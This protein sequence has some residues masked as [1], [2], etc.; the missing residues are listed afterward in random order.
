MAY[1]LPRI[2]D[3]LCALSGSS[4]FST[5]DLL[6]GYNQIE[7]CKADVPKTAFI[8]QWGLYEFVRMPFGLKGAPATCQRVVDKIIAGKKYVSVVVYLDDVVVYNKSFDDQLIDL[9]DVLQRFKAADLRFRPDKCRFLANSIQY[10]GHI[11]TDEGIAADPLKLRAVEHFPVPTDVNS[12]RSFLGLT[13]YF[14]K[15]VRGYANLAAPLHEMTKKNELFVMTSERLS[16]FEE[17]KSKLVSAPLLAHFDC[18][19]DIEIHTDASDKGLGAILIQRDEDGNERPVVFLSRSL[20]ANEKS[21][22]TVEKE[23][24]AVVWALDKL[25]CYIYGK[26]FKIITDNSSL[27]WL[28]RVKEGSARLLRWAMRL[29]EFEFEVIHKAGNRNQGPDALSRCPLPVE[30]TEEHDLSNDMLSLVNAVE[31]KRVKLVDQLK[32]SKLQKIIDALQGKG[33]KKSRARMH[34]RYAI[35]DDALYR[36]MSDK[37]ATRKCLC[38]PNYLQNSI[39]TEFHCG[40]SG[41]HMGFD[42]TYQRI[43][44][45]YFWNNM[46]RDINN[47]VKSCDTCQRYQRRYGPKVGHLHPITAN[48]PFEVVGIDLIGPLPN[49]KGGHRF[50]IVAIDYLT[51]YVESKALRSIEA[52]QIQNFIELT[53]ILRHGCPRKIIS[54]RGSQFV[55]KETE[56]LLTARGIELVHTTA[57]KPN[58]NGEVERVN[59]TLKQMLY[60]CCQ[61][62][63]GLWAE[64]L[65]YVVFTYNNS[66]QEATGFD[67]F[68]LVYGRQALLPT[69]VRLGLKQTRKLVSDDDYVNRSISMLA[70]ARK[71]AA[72]NIKSAQDKYCRLYN[73]NRKLEHFEKG[74]LVLLRDCKQTFKSKPFTPKYRGPFVVLEPL[75]ND[76]YDIAE[77][78]S[79]GELLWHDVVNLDKLKAYVTPVAELEQSLQLQPVLNKNKQPMDDASE[80]DGSCSSEC[81]N[82]RPKRKAT[83]G[84]KYYDFVLY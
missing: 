35:T 72:E 47:F 16:A 10:L 26:R 56:R 9:E 62:K 20:Q 12:L 2:D 17:L 11:V 73:K 42:R 51:K 30:T 38:V 46:L 36:I 6:S 76:N 5:L 79:E 43:K 37:L 18:Q 34:A 13:S 19:R 59:Q 45:R 63:Q 24:L 52:L 40:L 23:A 8:T 27:K 32:D 80:D 75:A 64:M 66:R 7:V 28:L 55:A 25:Y 4:C 14:R 57:Y 1:P 39:M 81:V 41:M 21:Y 29:Q 50:A 54:D 83:L 84:K 68:Y 31:A 67:P 15:F 44:N 22:A 78:G 70:K 60:R 71:I 65:P 3:V 61:K 33:S 53:I 74:Q 58:S 49:S 48:G 82:Q 77:F 69:D